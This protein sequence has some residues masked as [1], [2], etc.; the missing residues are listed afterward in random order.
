MISIDTY[1]VEFNNFKDM[2]FA[3]IDIFFGLANIIFTLKNE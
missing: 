3:Q 1:I 2:F